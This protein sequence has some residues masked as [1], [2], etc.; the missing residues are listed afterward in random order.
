MFSRNLLF[1]GHC[2]TVRGSRAHALRMRIPKNT[3]RTLQLMC[4]GAELCQAWNKSRKRTSWASK[5][6]VMKHE[7]SIAKR[8]KPPKPSPLPSPPHASLGRQR[9][10]GGACAVLLQGFSGTSAAL[11]QYFC[12]T[13]AMLLQCFCC[14]SAILWLYFCGTPG[15]LQRY[16]Q[17]YNGH[18]SAILLRYFN[19]ASGTSAVLFSWYV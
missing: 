1:G 5:E 3:K 13:S 8:K 9:F 18:A 11:L 19:G 14:T 17:R 12:S 15:A 7:V 4:C 2:A 6:P 10:F 16:F